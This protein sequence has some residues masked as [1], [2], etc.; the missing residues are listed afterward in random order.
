[1]CQVGGLTLLV[2]LL[3]ISKSAGRLPQEYDPWAGF[4]CV[5][6]SS[7]LI[8]AAFSCVAVVS[9]SVHPFLAAYSWEVAAGVSGLGYAIVREVVLGKAVA[10]ISSK[11]A[12]DILLRTSP[13]VIGNGC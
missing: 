10:R 9:R 6:V 5:L 13:A 11:E 2:L 7:T 1:L 4:L 12:G 8:A 3:G